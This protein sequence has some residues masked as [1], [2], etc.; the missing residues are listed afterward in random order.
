MRPTSELYKQLRIET[1]SYYESKVIQGENTYGVDVLKSIKI[2]PALFSGS[3][4]N[5]GNTWSI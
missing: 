1:G 4:P 2:T 3:G 5:M